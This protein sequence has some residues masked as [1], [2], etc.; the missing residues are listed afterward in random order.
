MKGDLDDPKAL[1]QEAYKIEN[2]TR[3]ECRSI[4]F[5]LG[6]KSANRAGREH[7]YSKFA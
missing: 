1:I 2:I 4:F 6:S 7:K 3:S 5:G